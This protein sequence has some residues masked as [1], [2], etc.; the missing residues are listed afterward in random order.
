[1]ATAQQLINQSLRVLGVI[2]AGETPSAEDSTDA[3]T[4][5]NSIISS[6]SLQKLTP[7]ANVQVT[8][9]LVVSQSSYTIGQSGSPDI[10]SIRPVDVV[11][12]FVRDGT[13]DY[14]VQIISQD[15]YDGYSDKTVTSSLPNRLFYDATYPNGT[16]Y[17]YPVPSDTNVLYMRVRRLLE[18]FVSLSEDVDLPT[19]S[20]RMLKYALARELSPEYGKQ[21]TADIERQYTEALADIKRLNAARNPITGNLMELTRSQRYNI[22]TDQG[23]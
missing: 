8:K 19:G 16:V 23:A 9:T 18:S 7:Y 5:L 17:L 12:S 6:L 1:M 20:D 13:S 10:S 2:G 21:I 4:A 22:Y 14:P 11:S 3:L 15:T